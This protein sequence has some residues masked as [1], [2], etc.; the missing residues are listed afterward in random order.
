VRTTFS[1]TVVLSAV[2]L[3]FTHIV[4][5]QDLFVAVSSVAFDLS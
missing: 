4:A 5:F 2:S 1:V 3:S